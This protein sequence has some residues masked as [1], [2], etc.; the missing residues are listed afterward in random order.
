MLVQGN[1]L[2]ESARGLVGVGKV[3]AR[4]QGVG[5]VGPQHAQD[6]GQVLLVQVDG[7]LESARGL[8]GAGEVVA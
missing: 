6:L 8:V 7:L 5:M 3:V 2:L 4:D 1:S